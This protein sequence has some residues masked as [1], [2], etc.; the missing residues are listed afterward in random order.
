MRKAVPYVRNVLAL[1]E[2]GK[3]SVENKN[4]SCLTRLR[5]T[6]DDTLVK[7]CQTLY[8]QEL[9]TQGALRE[10]FYLE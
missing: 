4:S 3:R 6:V 9:C 8:F 10:L 1:I 2:V 5:I 7:K